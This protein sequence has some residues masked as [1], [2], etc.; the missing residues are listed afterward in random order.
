MR[1]SSRR[2]ARWYVS[3]VPAVCVLAVVSI[4][5][6]ALGR[7]GTGAPALSTQGVRSNDL[8]RVHVGSLPSS[9]LPK[10]DPRLASA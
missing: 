10:L 7:S 6:A 3:I 2:S 5:A 9:S 8:E 4:P 1:P